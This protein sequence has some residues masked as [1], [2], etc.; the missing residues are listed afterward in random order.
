MKTRDGMVYDGDFVNGVPHGKVLYSPDITGTQDT[1]VRSG[2]DLYRA[3]IGVLPFIIFSPVGSH[4]SDLAYDVVIR[5][6]RLCVFCLTHAL[7]LSSTRLHVLYCRVIF[8]H[9]CLQGATPRD[10]CS[11]CGLHVCGVLLLFLLFL[12]IG[13][14]GCRFCCCCL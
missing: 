12:A 5:Y 1:D 2:V 6:I 14:G 3:I 13:C 8:A 7:L 9:V 11:C 4:T 10:T